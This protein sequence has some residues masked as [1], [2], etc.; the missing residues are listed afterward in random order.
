MSHISRALKELARE[1]NILV[2]T[3]SELNRAVENRADK[4]MKLSDLRDSG[5]LEQ[6]THIVMWCTTRRQSTRIRQM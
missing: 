6:H 2:L 5:A 1:L 4:V 3:M